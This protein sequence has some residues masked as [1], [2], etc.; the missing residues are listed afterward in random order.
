[1][2]WFGSRGRTRDRVLIAAIVHTSVIDIRHVPHCITE[3]FL[4]DVEDQ[5][6]ADRDGVLA[7]CFCF[8]F[9]FAGEHLRVIKLM[10]PTCYING[11]QTTET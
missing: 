9:S 1:M 7:G 3:F 8:K 6:T 4:E 11:G 5:P 10:A 2:F